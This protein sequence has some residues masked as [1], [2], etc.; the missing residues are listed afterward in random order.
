MGNTE[1]R[2]CHEAYEV[3]HHDKA[4]DLPDVSH[5]QLRERYVARCVFALRTC[6]VKSLLAFICQLPLAIFAVQRQSLRT[7]T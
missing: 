1:E 2:E 5:E 3:A 4:A 7:A 6:A